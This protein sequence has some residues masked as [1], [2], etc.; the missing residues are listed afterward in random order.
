MCR[1]YTSFIDNDNLY[2]LME[3]ASGG[4][5]YHL[6]KEHKKTRKLWSEKDIWWFAYE[7]LLG[8]E[9][10]HSKNIIHRDI[11]TLNIFTATDKHIKLGDLGVSKI[12]NSMIPLQGTRVG[13][14]LYLAP[15]LIRHQPYSFKVDIWAIGWALY[16]WCS[17]EP[18][19]VGDN[20]IVLGNTIVHKKPKAIPKSYSP[21][22]ALFIEKLLAKSSENRPSAKEALRMI[23]KSV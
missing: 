14:P 7:I 4:D 9:Y 6:L 22:L 2:I 12:V 21:K 1:Y 16:H 11:K 10:L 20:L 15:E 23:P 19:F 17:F 18:P 5:L 8:V 3:F 13:T